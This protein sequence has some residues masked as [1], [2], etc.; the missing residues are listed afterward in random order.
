MKTALPKFAR[1]YL[2]ALRQYLRPGARADKE[3]AQKLGLRAAAMKLATLDLAHLHDDCLHL[4]VSHDQPPRASDATVRR[5]RAFFAEAL[6]PMEESHRI[7][8]D[9]NTGLK[10]SI[11]AL[12]QRSAE[13]A[14]A[15]DKLHREMARRRKVEDS[16]RRS[17]AASVKLL[18]ESGHMQ[19]E[20]RLLSRRLLTVQENERK[21]ISR[22]LH[23]V[24][25]QTLAGVNLRLSTLKVQSAASTKDLQRKIA[26]TQ[27]L[28]EKSVAIVHRFA[29]DL[30]PAV[31]DDLGLIPAM[32]SFI[33]GFTAETG[34][35]VQLSAW[36]GAEKRDG[37]VRTAL[38]RVMQE[39][40][41]NAAHHAHATQA[42]VRIANRRGTLRMEITDDGKGFKPDTAFL[43]RANTR[44]GLLGMRERVEMVGGTFSIESTPAVA[45]TIRVDFPRQ[46]QIARPLPPR[47]S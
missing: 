13:L 19:E 46:G 29:R 18:E 9:A 25:G 28:V 3:A 31:L 38:F 7:L 11:R 44:L 41:R 17:E 4:L 40:L 34:L 22:E 14:R 26:V 5:A 23:D 10:H 8:R 43:A 30:R 24:V 39:A 12:T 32:E 16:L 27:R 21:A 36:S 20:L 47:A 1:A 6:T 37:T 33:A 15:N 42:W 2:R 45:T 35:P